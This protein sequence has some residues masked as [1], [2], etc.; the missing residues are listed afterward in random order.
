MKTALVTGSTGFVGRNLVSKLKKEGV[1]VFSVSTRDKEASLWVKS[2]KDL[3]NSLKALGLPKI[4]VFYHLA[5]NGT[6]SKV[7]DD[8]DTQIS[9]MELTME[10][11]K[12]ACSLGPSKTVVLGSMSEYAGFKEKVT[13]KDLPAPSDLYSVFKAGSRILWNFYS[14]KKSLPLIY[15]LG[16]TT[17]GP[18]RDD[19][20]V[21]T[22]TIKSLL[23]GLVP[24]YTG[25]EQ[26]WDYI[27]I[28]DFV[29]GLY[30]VGEKGKA[31]RTYSLGTGKAAPLKEYIKAARDAIDPAL[32]IKIGALPYKTPSI[33]NSM[34]DIG[35]LQED[36]G[37][38]AQV[39]FSKG[40]KET[41]K[42]FKMQL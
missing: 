15:V 42:Y 7:K 33:D 11:I 23:R 18:G 6:D 17:Y 22:Y 29:R 5:W 27:Y 31:C 16:G 14:K 28:D 32:P 39:D 35:E 8:F 36:T 2:Y 25:L 13:G 12:A 1:S 4:D 10:V 41:I 19:S 38:R 24:E 37:F 34:P 21:L 26:M 20:N 3:C 30:L 40:I 9:N